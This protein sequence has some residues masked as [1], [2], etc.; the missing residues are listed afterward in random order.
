MMQ[1]YGLAKCDGFGWPYKCGNFPQMWKTQKQPFKFYL[2]CVARRFFSRDPIQGNNNRFY[3]EPLGQLFKRIKELNATFIRKMSGFVLAS[4]FSLLFAKWGTF[5]LRVG[6]TA[7]LFP[8]SMRISHPK[9]SEHGWS[10]FGFSLL[11]L[12]DPPR[13]QNHSDRSTQNTKQ[14]V[15]SN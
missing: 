5:H 7:N 6:V 9:Y 4:F 13:D 2:N 1:C 11:F 14:M 3:A 15:Q 8:N 10:V 12:L